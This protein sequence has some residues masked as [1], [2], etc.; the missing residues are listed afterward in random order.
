MT[1]EEFLEVMADNADLFPEFAALP[2]QQQ[3]AMANT[4]IVT[5]PA[6][7]FRDTNG[8]LVGVGGIRIIG[9]AEAWLITPKDI[10]SHPDY[11]KRKQQFAEFLKVSKDTFKKMCD[12]NRLWRVFARGTLSMSFLEQFGFERIDKIMVWSRKE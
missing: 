6:Q 3:E 4:N 10:R 9:V 11:Q 12:E 2:Q 8:R 7:A 5:G 1:T